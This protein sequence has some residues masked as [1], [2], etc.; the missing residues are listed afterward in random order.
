MAEEKESQLLGL[1][2]DT[3]FD[4][5]FSNVTSQKCYLVTSTKI[6]SDLKFCEVFIKPQTHG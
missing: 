2:L 1:G 6:V 5:L 4:I 3:N